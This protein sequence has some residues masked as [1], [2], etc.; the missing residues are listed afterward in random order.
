MNAAAAAAATTSARARGDGGGDSNGNGNVGI[1]IGAASASKKPHLVVVLADDYGWASIGYHA[2]PGSRE[3]QTPNLDAL[4][5]SGV[6]LERFYTYKICS[7]S[8]SSLQTGR[9][10]VHVNTHNLA[11]E[12][13]NPSD[14]VSGYAAI[15]RN[16]TGVA[17][18]LKREGYRTVMTGKWDA[19]M[20]TPRHT[21]R[22]RGYDAFLGYFHVR[23]PRAPRSVPARRAH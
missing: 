23:A 4:A 18:K 5:A 14:P 11:P 10:P 9:L 16:M 3:V 2:P 1:G 8:R 13:I 12:S 22:G 19:G 21:P 7:P 17:E 6:K 15:P 20:A